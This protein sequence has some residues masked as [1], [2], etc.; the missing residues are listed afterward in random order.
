LSNLT[1]EL[2]R[3][4]A[5]YYSQN[6]E[7]GVIERLLELVG[8]TNRFYVEFGVGNGDECNTRLLRERGWSGLMMDSACENP[9]IGLH[10]E[11][12]TAE[13]INDLLVKHHVPESFD[14]LSI[15]IDGN[16][17]WVWKAMSARFRA[18][19][20]VIEYNCA[21]PAEIAVA[22]PYDPA[23][24]WAGEAN[25]GQSL[26]ALKK[27][28]RA[29][30][31]SLVYADAPNAFLVLNSLLPYWRTNRSVRRISRT[32]WREN[33]ERRREWTDRLRH[34]PWVYV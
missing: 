32:T 10:R 19:V 33:R 16:D 29:R 26:L 18:R 22:M 30:G 4:Q 5:R 7:D 27:L 8:V 9:S 34:L 1:E 14:L 24:R 12:V 25:T 6:G 31:Y 21:V 20:V 23:F 2:H 11:F 15:D 28:A 3:R 17:H 13:N